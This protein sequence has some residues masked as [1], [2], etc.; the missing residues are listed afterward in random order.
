MPL[1]DLA[2][3]QNGGWLP[4][5]A[6][7]KVAKICEVAE[8]RVFEVASF[9]TM[10][11]RTPIGKHFVQVCTTTPCMI[12]GAYGILSAIEKELGIECGETTSDGLFTLGQVKN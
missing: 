6:M 8:I 5:S 4:V 11:N 9:Y 3:R 12:R 7:R 1:L 10:Y 2:Q